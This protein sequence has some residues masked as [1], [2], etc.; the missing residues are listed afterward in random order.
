MSEY[1]E[2]KPTFNYEADA[3][4]IDWAW[5]EMIAE[6]VSNPETR[7]DTLIELA[8]VKCESDESRQ[9]SVTGLGNH[10]GFME[11]CE[12]AQ[13]Y[14]H[15]HWEE[16]MT[17]HVDVI[18][19]VGLG[20]WNKSPDQTTGDRVIRML[21]DSLRTVSKRGTDYPARVGGDEFAVVRENGNPD[22]GFVENL[23][24]ELDKPERFIDGKKIEIYVGGESWNG[25]S[26]SEAV[27]KTA[28]RRMTREKER[29]APAKHTART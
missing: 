28:Q 5:A 3:E 10:R 25:A 12:L 7:E 16:G 21:A 27:Y 17:Y 20:D 29:S 6:R 24:K 1:S 23:L 2:K 15:R 11:R 18:D 8:K 4:M 26:E 22:D 9:D 19:V 13:Q 14:A